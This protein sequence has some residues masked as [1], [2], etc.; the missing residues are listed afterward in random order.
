MSCDVLGGGEQGQLCSVVHDVQLW[1][2]YATPFSKTQDRVHDHKDR[3]TSSKRKGRMKGG[4]MYV[5]LTVLRIRESR[6]S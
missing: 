1:Y 2:N 3:M 4:C 6:P 5:W